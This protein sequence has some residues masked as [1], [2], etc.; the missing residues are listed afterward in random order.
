MAIVPVAIKYP[1]VHHVDTAAI[2]VI[3]FGSATSICAYLVEFIAV[4]G[5][6]VIYPTI[7]NIYCIRYP[8]INKLCSIASIYLDFIELPPI[9]A[10]G[11][12]SIY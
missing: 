9:T 11:I 3:E 5:I 6:A 10:L 1:I 4:V 7:Y 8:I 2:I 12:L